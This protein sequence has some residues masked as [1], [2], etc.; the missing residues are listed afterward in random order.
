MVES[1]PRGRTPVDLLFQSRDPQLVRLVAPGFMPETLAVSPDPSGAPVKR[2]D[3]T[4]P[5]G[6]P[7]RAGSPPPAA[8]DGAAARDFLPGPQRAP[9]PGANVYRPVAD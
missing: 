9:R 6:R 5:R 4:R 7:R 8:R 1:S 3:L 2:A